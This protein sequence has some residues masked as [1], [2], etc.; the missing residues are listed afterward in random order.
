DLPN[1]PNRRIRTRTYGG[2]GGEESRDSPLSRSQSRARQSVLFI[3]SKR[4]YAEVSCISL[5]PWSAP[6]SG[7]TFVRENSRNEGDKND[8]QMF[9]GHGC[10]SRGPVVEHRT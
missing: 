5:F 3:L 9:D 6:Y 7:R 2:V 4:V 8:S 1:S 10:S